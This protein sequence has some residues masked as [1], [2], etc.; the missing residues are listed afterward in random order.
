MVTSL[1]TNLESPAER[2]RTIRAVTRNAKQEHDALGGDLIRSWAELMTPGLVTTA[3]RLYSKYRL[4]E[5]HRPMF[6]LMISNVPGPRVPIYFAGAE[7]VAAYP[8]GPISEGAGLNITVFSY[9]KHVDFGFVTSPSLI[10]DLD[11]LAALIPEAA[12]ELLIASASA[13]LA[14]SEPPVA[15]TAASN[16]H[17]LPL[18]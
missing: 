6:N 5:L 17:K 15:A 4:S 8:L 12:H 7:L 16:V 18:R 14:A 13:A 11:L 3:A 9:A 2:L 10:E 1:A